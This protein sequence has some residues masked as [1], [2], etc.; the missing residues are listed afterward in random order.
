[1]LR[2]TIN[3]VIML[4]GFLIAVAEMHCRSA[5]LRKY[6]MLIVYLTEY[7]PKQV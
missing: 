6:G 5:A 2:K 3:P 4:L 7:R 1:M